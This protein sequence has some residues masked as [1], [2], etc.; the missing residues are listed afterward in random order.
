M[1]FKAKKP[2][3]KKEVSEL[4][5]LFDISQTLD[6]SIDL[7]EV[8]GRVLEAI[9]HHMG[10]LRSTLTLLNRKT[11][12]IFIEA[13]YGLSLSQKERGRYKLGEGVTGKVF[14]TGKPAV[15]PRISKEPLFLNK[16]GAR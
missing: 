13:A 7:R 3:I 12:E 14:T 10:M 4:S 11:G 5:L 16:T 9:A 8:V 6:R 2:V 1:A 15:I